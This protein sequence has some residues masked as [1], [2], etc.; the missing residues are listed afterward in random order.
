MAAVAITPASCL[1]SGAA[2]IIDGTAGATLTAGMVVFQD[3]DSTWKP[4]T[5]NGASPT[6]KAAGIVVDGGSAGQPVKICTSDPAFTPGGTLVKG[7]VY[8]AGST[9]GA[10]NPTTDLTTGW[11]ASVLGVAISATVMNLFVMKNCRADV[12]T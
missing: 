6:Y 9:A 7:T 12:A 10:I 5:A 11:F 2:V 1:P 3:V 8:V 4:C